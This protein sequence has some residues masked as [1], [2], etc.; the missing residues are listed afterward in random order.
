MEML[1]SWEF[2]IQYDFVSPESALTGSCVD[3]NNAVIDGGFADIGSLAS[4]SDFSD[5]RAAAI[6]I[7]KSVQVLAQTI[8]SFVT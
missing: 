1:V 6:H 4:V 2:V 5:D 3:E 7:G 8:L